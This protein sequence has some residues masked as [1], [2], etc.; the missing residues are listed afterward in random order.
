MFRL[1]T[2]ENMYVL[3]LSMLMIELSPKAIDVQQMC[4]IAYQLAW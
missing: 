1:I 3:T 2:A 4:S